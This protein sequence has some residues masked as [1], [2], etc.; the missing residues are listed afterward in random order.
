[1]ISPPER[2]LN[3][4]LKKVEPNLLNPPLKKVEP[5]TF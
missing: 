5:K 2:F 3:P 1:M 4:P